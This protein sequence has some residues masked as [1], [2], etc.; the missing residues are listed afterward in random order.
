MDLE[1]RATSVVVD[2][3]S[4]RGEDLGV[5]MWGGG[6][7]GGEL[8]DLLVIGDPG[9]FMRH[10]ET[11]PVWMPSARATAEAA[12]TE[13]A[14][15]AGGRGGPP[16]DAP[17]EQMWRW[18]VQDTAGFWSAVAE[19]C[20]LAWETRPDAVTDGAPMPQTRW[21]PVSIQM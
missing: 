5:D 9:R 19:F 21:F 2:G 20:E 13:F 18:S 15:F 17:Y 10:D 8:G 14:R 4:C 11:T 16:S 3:V 7:I 6:E 1:R 12:I